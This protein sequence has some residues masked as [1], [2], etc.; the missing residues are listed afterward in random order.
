[1]LVNN[2]GATESKSNFNMLMVMVVHWVSQL[3]MMMN[4]VW[5]SMMYNVMWSSMM[6][7]LMVNVMRSSMVDH[8][9]TSV[10]NHMMLMVVSWV[11][12][13]GLSGGCLVMHNILAWYWGSSVMGWWG[14]VVCELTS[15]GWGWVA[16]LGVVA[17]WS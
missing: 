5:T 10:V 16:S 13:H 9:V 15:R 17:T 6:D 1:M 14:T 4:M 8:M 7:N 11:V 2:V 12:M 3:N